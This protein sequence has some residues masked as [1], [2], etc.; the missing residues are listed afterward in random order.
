M[1]DS[2]LEVSTR[3]SV[4][5]GGRLPVQSEVCIPYED[6]EALS[7]KRLW[8]SPWKLVVT[9]VAATPGALDQI[10]PARGRI[11]QVQ[12]LGRAEVY[13]RIET[14]V[15]LRIAEAKSEAYERRINEALPSGEDC[16]STL[17][18][19]HKKR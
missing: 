5:I 11:L 6:I 15:N 18:S 8:H 14:E 3:A 13:K 10:E 2:G 12:L 9:L 17:K 16:R 4:S 7:S 1:L 19:S